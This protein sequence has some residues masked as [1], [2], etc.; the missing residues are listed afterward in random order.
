M[1]LFDINYLDKISELFNEALKLKK[2]KAMPPVLAVFCG[3][4]MMPYYF[5]SVIVAI[6]LFFCAFIFETNISFVKS[7][8]CI[9]N[10]QTKTAH[11]AAQVVLYWFSW[12]LVFFLYVIEGVLLCF[13]IPIYAFLSVLIYI[14]SFG[15]IKFHLFAKKGDDISIEVTEPYKVVPI[16]FVVI[17]YS[18]LVVI[19][20]L[21]GVIHLI[22]LYYDYKEMRFI[23]DFTQRIYPRYF[24]A[25]LLFT[26]IFSL[27]SIKNKPNC[28][29]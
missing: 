10:D 18:L 1:N 25:H 22:D 24:R 4:L 27:V 15:G 9:L 17:G 13:M 7:L 6:F 5:A 19:P 29:Q 2:Y 14:W 12:P 21:H 16:F 26:M 3:I 8:H 20:L 11:P 23:Y 28:D